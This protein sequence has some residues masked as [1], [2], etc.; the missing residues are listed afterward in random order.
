MDYGLA[1]ALGISAMMIFGLWAFWR[2]YKKKSAPPAAKPDR[3]GRP[4]ALSKAPESSG[5]PEGKT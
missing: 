2:G 3:E 5:E 1:N 4:R